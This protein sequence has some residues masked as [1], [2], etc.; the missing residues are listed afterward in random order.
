MKSTMAA[1]FNGG[2][3][4]S[5]EHL[6]FTDGYEV[7]FADA[8]RTLRVALELPASEGLTGDPGCM[9]GTGTLD[10]AVPGGQD[11]ILTGGGRP[12]RGGGGWE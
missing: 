7:G 6:A 3:E 1:A 12:T 9:P 8:L 2:Q 4:I 5:A 11:S 10:R